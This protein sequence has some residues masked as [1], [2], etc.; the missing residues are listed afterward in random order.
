MTTSYGEPSYGLSKR[1]EGV[2]HEEAVGRVTESLKR[3]GFGVLTTID[4]EATLAAKLGVQFGRKYVILG[5]CNPAL[6]NRALSAEPGVGLLLPCNVVV[7]EE[8]GRAVV[9]AVDPRAMFAVVGKPEVE[10]I[11][12]EVYEK[13]AR[14][15]ESL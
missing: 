8:E 7:T 11:A 2:A 13:L 15:I 12:A 10:P 14:V 5:A 4:V 9:S 6:A 1:L 3:E